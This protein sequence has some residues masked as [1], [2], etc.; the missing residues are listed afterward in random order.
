M[1]D[2]ISKIIKEDEILPILAQQSEKHDEKLGFL[3][4]VPYLPNKLFWGQDHRNACNHLSPGKSDRR[5]ECVAYYWILF[6]P[7][8]SSSTINLFQSRVIVQIK[9]KYTTKSD[10]RWVTPMSEVLIWSLLLWDSEGEVVSLIDR[11]GLCKP[12]FTAHLSPW[13]L[14]L[15]P[16][17]RPVCMDIKW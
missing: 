6:F 12:M 17:E 8:I 11:L 3:V 4:V 10:N 15:Q 16:Y 2:K 13:D 1:S 9:G 14:Q 5:S 7:Q